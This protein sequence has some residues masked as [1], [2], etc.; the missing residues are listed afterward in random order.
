MEREINGYN[1][2][3]Y[4]KRSNMMSMVNHNGSLNIIQDISL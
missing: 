4:N 2:F 3:A 1:I